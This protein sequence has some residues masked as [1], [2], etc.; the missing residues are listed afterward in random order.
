MEYFGDQAGFIAFYIIITFCT[1]LLPVRTENCSMNVLSAA[2]FCMNILQMGFEPTRQFKGISY[3]RQ[4][5]FVGNDGETD[6]WNC[7]TSSR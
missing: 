5:R 7:Y 3:K 2:R 6:P 4:F 1:F